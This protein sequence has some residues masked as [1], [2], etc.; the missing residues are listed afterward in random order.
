MDSLGWLGPAL[1]LAAR[2]GG[3]ACLFLAAARLALPA[4]ML[5]AARIQEGRSFRRGLWIAAPQL[6]A[7]ALG[8][9]G[10]LLALSLNAVGLLVLT[11][12]PGFETLPLRADN[13]LHYGLPEEAIAL[14]IATALAAIAPALLFVGAARVVRSR[15]L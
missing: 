8:A 9:A 10:I 1:C 5:E 15:S 14:A 12:P 4:E 3:P 13:L 6:A 11:V 7:P 2:L